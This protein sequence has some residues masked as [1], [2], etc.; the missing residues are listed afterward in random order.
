MHAVAADIQRWFDDGAPAVAVATVQRTWGSAP[1]GVGSAMAV[2][3]NGDFSGSVSG[4]CVEAAVLAAALDLLA[5]DGRSR[6]LAFDVA[7]ATAW[8]VGL[9]CGGRLEVWLERW[10][11]AAWAPVAAA[12]A[13]DG[14]G[15]GATLG[16]LV[17]GPPDRIGWRALDG[18][19]VAD[20]IGERP[21]DDA[22]GRLVTAVDGRQRT[23]GGAS[24]A[25]F[26]AAGDVDIDVGIGI[27]VGVGAD[28][29]IGADV[30]EGVDVGI[31]EA[32]ID[33]EGRSET[34]FE[35][36]LGRP[37]DV[38]VVGAGAIAV[39][40]AA[41][42]AVVGRPVTVVDP[43]RAFATRARFPAPVRLVHAWPAEALADLAITPRTAIVVLSH[44]PKLDDPA[45]AAALASS[46]GYIGA[47]GGRASQAAR[48]DRLRSN[49]WSAAD[50]DRVHGPIGLAIGARTPAEIAVAI[51]AEI[52]AA[53]EASP[54]PRSAPTRR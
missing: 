39:A 41:L 45:L 24:E 34:W 6:S 23:S 7:D 3:P 30:G 32:G 46:A 9:A 40:L 4:G 42:C 19:A 50:V 51:L 28:I 21:A 36:V 16:R 35:V 14:D 20:A 53:I 48:R 43:R 37:P 25:A 54:R 15:D 49:G 2:A 26:D 31:G 44:D 27:G 38:V 5:G 29:D 47:L 52:I 33:G 10:T 11:P 1:L 13:G 8:S 22:D 17:A 18:Q 12:L